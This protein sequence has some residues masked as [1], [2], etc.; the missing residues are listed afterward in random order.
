[1]RARFG[2]LIE[3][4]SALPEA[5]RHDLRGKL[6]VA[7]AAYGF[8]DE[9][10]ALEASS[11]AK[12][13]N[14]MRRALACTYARRGN[15]RDAFAMLD[16]LGLELSEYEAFE[17]MADC[18]ARSARPE[19]AR[20]IA[21]QVPL[22]PGKSDRIARIVALTERET[23][24]HA[25]AREAALSIEDDGWRANTLDQLIGR[26]QRDANCP[27]AI[28][29]ERLLLDEARKPAVAKWRQHALRSLLADVMNSHTHA[30]IIPVVLEF[31]ADDRGFAFLCVLM[32]EDDPDVIRDLAR[33]FPEFSSQGGL[34]TDLLL[35]R[36]RVGDLKPIDAVGLAP[37]QQDFAKQSIRLAGR[38]GREQ[39]DLAREVLQ[40]AIA[41]KGKRPHDFWMNIAWAQ[42][43][44]GLLDEA[45]RTVDK[46]IRPAG[47]R[48]TALMGVSAAE[49][50]QG[51]AEDAA[52]SRARAL[53]L[54]ESD[55]GSADGFFV[56]Y[57]LM[58]ADYPEA[59][60]QLI[61]A[62][63]QD[64]RARFSYD[65]VSQ[66]VVKSLARRGD[67]ERALELAQA[68]AI[69]FEGSPEPFADVYTAA[70]GLPDFIVRFTLQ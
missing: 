51:K 21:T 22:T 62:A 70:N 18:I 6:A 34:Q 59:A 25:A 67:F 3:Q 31:P 13:R 66:K 32:G 45:H 50:A 29:T 19:F 54:L 4:A 48:G 47:E 14:E 37:D 69:H 28:A 57:Y 52:R 63:T 61:L 58:D 24:H 23:G 41:A 9:A 53:K 16:A 30:E 56:T 10:L 44:L 68:L 2:A 20:A 12:A 15:F 46:K 35:A 38:L 43:R 39:L 5:D 42:A 8:V 65:D 17:D 1:M 49:A 7:M 36:V 55:E 33:G 64:A 60:Q 27:E 11:S 40:S 26:Y